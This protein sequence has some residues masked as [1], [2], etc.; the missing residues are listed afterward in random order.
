M[1]L[2]SAGKT[3]GGGGGGGRVTNGQ[4]AICSPKQNPD[5]VVSAFYSGVF[6]YLIGGKRGYFTPKK[7][8]HWFKF[9][10]G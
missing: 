7:G 8:E 5:P 6:S 3:F 4:Q 10:Y 1:P 9:L 2:L